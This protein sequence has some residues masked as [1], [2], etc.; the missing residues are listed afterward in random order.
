MKKNGNLFNFLKSKYKFLEINFFLKLHHLIDH[1]I[2]F[3][4][5]PRTFFFE[6]LFYCSFIKKKLK[7]YFHKFQII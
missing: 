2:F 1:I 4:F 6:K 3:R 5:F 7:S